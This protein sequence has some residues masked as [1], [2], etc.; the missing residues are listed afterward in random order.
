MKEIILTKSTG[1]KLRFL[2][3]FFSWLL[4][5]PSL[6]LRII[7]S[8]LYMCCLPR[9]KT[10]EY[11][12]VVIRPGGMGD[13]VLACKAFETLN[14]QGRSVIWVIQKRAE[15]WAIQ[16]N[17][18]YVILDSSS[19]A[20][21]AMQGIKSKYVVNSEQFYGLGAII[22]LLVM[23]NSSILAGFNSN[24]FAWIHD[25]STSYQSK[26]RHEYLSFIDLFE[27]IGMKPM[28]NK[29]MLLKRSVKALERGILTLG[30]AGFNCRSRSLSIDT[31]MKYTEIALTKADYKRVIV[32]CQPSDLKFSA[33]LA[34][35]LRSKNY[36]NVDVVEGGFAEACLAI[37]NAER[38][39]T[40]DGGLV[41]VASYY[42]IPV[43]AIFTA[44]DPYK[45]HPLEETSTII[46]AKNRLSC[47]PCTYY[48]KIARC[49]KK[50]EC[51]ALLSESYIQLLVRDIAQTS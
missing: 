7:R 48:G 29:S 46:Y 38:V 15:A 14:T 1:A 32:I 21:T 5:L 36:V 49:N 44:G 16:N 50:Y 4:L 24:R 18:N 9:K 33:K 12:C 6:A 51:R 41:H 42:G 31:W 17:M 23:H 39:L 25:K 28:K 37:Q 34:S 2:D 30:I 19:F 27:L 20:G 47:M 40:V 8:R 10:P 26:G 43:D 35:R 45:W 22:A 3:S 11:D 13:L